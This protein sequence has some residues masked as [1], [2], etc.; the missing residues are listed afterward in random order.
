VALRNKQ[1]ATV[2]AGRRVFLLR[3]ASSCRST[4]DLFAAL[5]A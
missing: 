4:T 1:S 2:I 3:I 5:A